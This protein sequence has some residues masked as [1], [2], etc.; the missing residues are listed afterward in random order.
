[1]VQLGTVRLHAARRNKDQNRKQGLISDVRDGAKNRFTTF[2]N[3][4]SES[5][6][7]SGE[8]MDLLFILPLD[9]VMGMYSPIFTLL[10]RAV[11]V[12]ILIWCDGQI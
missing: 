8:S 9:H 12:L 4:R 3:Q 7:V 1:M 6:G 2:I 5:A 11:L 10:I